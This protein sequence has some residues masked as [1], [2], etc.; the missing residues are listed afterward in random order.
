MGVRCAGRYSGK[1]TG[2]P[3]VAM[4][5]PR[6][7]M[8]VAVIC[9][10]GNRR[11]GP[12]PASLVAD[13]AQAPSTAADRPAAARPAQD[14]RVADE[15][16]LRGAP[17]ARSDQRQGD[18]EPGDGAHRPVRL[19]EV[20][21]PALAQ[22]DERHHPRHARRGRGPHRRPGYLRALGR[23]RQSA[24]AGRDGVPEIEPVSEVDLRERRLRP[25]DQ[26]HDVAR[27]KN[28]AGGSRPA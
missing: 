28:C 9:S 18:A 17:R 8:A 20:D 26:P 21:V 13:A 25:A 19:R 27:A 3:Y 4:A 12:T 1:L 11:T 24:P 7:A 2:K 23:R 5:P 15:L 10:R 6:E 22:P 16:L 14:R